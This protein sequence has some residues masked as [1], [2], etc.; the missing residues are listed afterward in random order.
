MYFCAS[1]R[2]N[3]R[4][5]D[6]QALLPEKSRAQIDHILRN[7]MHHNQ[8]ECSYLPEILWRYGRASEALSIWLAMTDPGYERREYPEISFA[9]VGAMVNGYMGIRPDAVSRTVYTRSAVPEWQWAQINDLP[10]WGGRL[11]IRH[12]GQG[13]SVLENLTGSD[14]T[15]VADVDGEK[16]VLTVPIGVEMIALGK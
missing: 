7:D 3:G 16:K 15:W 8:E 12:D 14:L 9:V 6:I 1:F 11:R 2:K 13:K 5:R 4:I 10:L